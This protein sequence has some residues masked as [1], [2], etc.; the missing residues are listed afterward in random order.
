LKEGALDCS[1]WRTP[2]WRG[3]GPVVR[4][5]IDWMKFRLLD[6]THIGGY[7]ILTRVIISCLSWI[8]TWISAAKSGKYS[9]DAYSINNL[10][11]E[12][13]QVFCAYQIRCVPFWKLCLKSLQYKNCGTLHYDLKNEGCQA[14][15]KYGLTSAVV[16]IWTNI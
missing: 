7:F 14:E 10:W 6:V 16:F 12:I 8:L 11:L 4:L 13:S 2:F 1:L 3:Y 9:H 5:E 15:W